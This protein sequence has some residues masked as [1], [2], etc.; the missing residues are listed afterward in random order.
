MGNVHLFGHAVGVIGI[1]S[2]VDYPMMITNYQQIIPMKKAA[3]PSAAS[4]MSQL[5]PIKKVAQVPVPA[6]ADLTTV[7]AAAG[8]TKFHILHPTLTTGVAATVAPLL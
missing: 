4:A 5:L 6:P 1:F 2:I 3:Y 7:P 8:V